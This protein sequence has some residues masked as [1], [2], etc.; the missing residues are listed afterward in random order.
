MDKRLGICCLIGF[1]ICFFAPVNSAW[2]YGDEVLAALSTSKGNIRSGN[3][4]LHLGLEARETFDDNIFNTAVD[5]KDDLITTITPGALVSMGTR[6]KFEF[7]YALGVHT[8]GDYSDEDFVSQHGRVLVDMNLPSGV[9]F[10]F[11]DTY[12]KTEDPRP[13]ELQ[14]R[15]SHKSNDIDASVGYEFPAKKLTIEALYSMRYL[16]FDQPENRPINK[17]RNIFGVAIYYKF[18]PKTSALFEYKL[19]KHD[20]FDSIDENTDK[21]AEI[22][23]VMAGVK[24]DATAKLSG[25]I[26]TGWKS[27]KYENQR[28]A[29]G[30]PYVDKSLWSVESLLTYALTERTKINIALNRSLED[31]EYGGNFTYSR[32]TN[33]LNTGAMAGVEHKLNPKLALNLNMGVQRHKYN[34]I[35][36]TLLEREDEIADFGIGLTYKMRDWLGAAVKYTYYNNSSDDPTRDE[37]HNKFFIS[38]GI[39]I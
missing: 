11:V 15:A 8:Y 21:D 6:H 5:Q 22:H 33:Y 38:V 9:R 16:K 7:G 37:R 26:K 18:L 29:L 31:T 36:P 20:Y 25:T 2:A 14:L 35:Q 34:K 30:N 27:K 28:D 23:S 3:L 12:L 32:A 17:I 10:D 1:V 4:R 24:W 13:E 39:A 19:G